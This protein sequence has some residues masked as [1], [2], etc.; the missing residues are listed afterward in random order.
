MKMNAGAGAGFDAARFGIVKYVFGFVLFGAL[1]L[2]CAGR[3]D[4]PQADAPAPDARFVEAVS[5][6]VLGRTEP[7]RVVFTQGRDTS[8]PLPA[9]V[10]TLRPAAGGAVSWQDEYTLVFTPSEP[11]TAGRRYQAHVKLG[12]IEPFAFDFVTAL[13]GLDVTLDPV[14]I[15]VYGNAFVRGRVNAD[16]GT[17]IS[18]IEAAVSSRELG[19]PVWE[20]EFGTH[21][22]TFPGVTLRPASHTVEVEWN[23]RVLGSRDS[24]SAAVS[25][26]GADVFEVT[27]F[28][29]ND[30]VL[31]VSF[32]SPLMANRDLRGFISMDGNTNVRYSVDRNIVRVFG[33]GS[34]GIPPGT[35][36]LF[37][38]IEAHDGRRLAIPVQHRTPVRWELPQIRFAGSG[39]ILPT[40][41]GS[42]MV[43]ET[44][45]VS[46]VLV[47]AFR[48][49]G[50]NMIQFLQVNS[51]DGER[52]LDRVGEPVWTKAFDFPW[53][54]RD[55]NRWIRRGLDL[56]EL[57]R[58]YPDGMFRIRVTFRQRHVRFECTAGHG[59][60]EHLPFPDDTF[61][62]F[63]PA[64]DGEYSGWDFDWGIAMS[65]PG[66]NW[67]D[68]NRFRHDPCHPSFFMVH[69]D[70]NITIGRNVLVSDLGLLARRS[71]DGS[72]L[73]ATTN[74]ISARPERN[75]AF[76]IY[77]FQGRV[78][79]E[80]RTGP[81]GMARVPRLE[82]ARN[83]NRFFVSAESG[84][85][86]AFLRVQ[87]ALALATSHFDVAGGS[88]STDVRGLIYGERGVWRPGD[89][90]YLTFLLSDPLQTLP[91]DHP[92]IFE[93]EDPRGRVVHQRTLTSSV[94][95]FYR[96]TTS[97]SADAPTGH[98]TARVRVGGNVFS[99][100]V[101]VET[102][103]PNRLRMDLDFGAEGMIRS[104]PQNV[105]LEAEWLF[106][107]PAPGLRADVS[108]AFADRETVFP[109]FADFSFR[110]PSRTVS[111]QRGNIWSGTLDDYG[112]AE[113]EMRLN[114]G[115][116]VP[117]MVT[118][119]FMTRVFEP[120][121]VFS[122]EQ[123]SVDYSPYERYVGIRLPRGDAARNMLLTDTDHEAE[124]VVLD[125]DG[126]PVPGEV[127][128]SVAL[129][130][131]N[132]RWWWERG[133]EEPAQFAS[134]LARSPVSRGN[135]T[136]V[137]GRASW[138]FR[139]NQPT[140]G[141]F[142]VIARDTAGGHAAAQVTFIDWPGWAGRPQEGGQDA[143]A[144]LT[145]T[146][147]RPSYNVGETV[148]VSFP[149]NRYATALV[150]V[151][152][153]GQIIRSEWVRGREGTTTIEFQAEP[154]M[155]PNVYVH[156]ALLQP[157]LQTQ[158]DLPIRLY[159]VTPVFIEDSRLILRPR[160]DAPEVWQAES[161][162]SF[163]V[164]EATGRPMAYT[165]AVVDEGLLG[166]T[167]FSLPNP[168]N[169]F[170]ARE[171]SFLKSWD[172]F[173]DVIGAHSGRLETLLAIGGGGAG[174]DADAARET[175]R[176]RPVV[177]FFGPYEL[178]AGGQ[179]THTFDLPPYIGALRVMVLAASATSERRPAGV[180]R[181]YGTAEQTVR[182]TSD[183]MV[184]GSL[185]RVLSP[186][187]EVVIPVHVNSYV[188]GRRTVRV[189]LSVP[190]A[191]ILGPV[192]RDVVFDAPGERL[193]RFRARAPEV[194]GDLTFTVSAESAGLETA[195]HVTEMEVRS[196]ALPVTR[197][198]HSLVA[199]GETWGGTLEYPGRDGT[200]RLSLTLSRLPPINLDARLSFLITYPHGCLEQTTSGLFPQLYL[201]RIV[202]L[203]D[204]RRA[205]IRTNVTVGIERIAAFQVPSGGFSFWP[206]GSEA[207]DWGT[208]YAG[209]FLLEA[210][211]AGFAVPEHV[212]QNWLRFQRERAAQWQARSGGFTEQA[213]RLY[214]LALA[215]QADLGSMNR[216]RDQRDLPLQARWRLAAAYWHS[217][218][219]DAA[220]NMTRDLQL[221]DDDRRELSGTFGSRL[222]D[223]AMVLQT[224]IL[225]SGGGAG[226]TDAA[227]ISALFADIAGTLSGDG[228]LSTQET[229][230]ALMAVAPYIRNNS[231]NDELVL[232]VAAAGSNGNVSF[233]GPSLE[234]PFGI[235]RGT[236]GGFEVTNNS[237]SPVYATF[238]VWGT[239]EE[240]GEPAVSDGLA[241][242]VAYLDTDGRPVEP[243]NLRLGQDMEVRVTVRNT[244]NRAVE[245]IALV[246][247]FPA[248]LEIIN[249][250]LAGIVGSQATYRF[251]DIRDDRVKTYFDL[252]RGQSRTF[253]F[254]VTKTYEGYFFRPAIHVYAMY[255]ESIRALIPGVR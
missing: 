155:V 197:S 137:D 100:T 173:R 54:A 158:N 98:W 226:Q 221:P 119:R 168:R 209:H 192:Y 159:G 254:R 139:V 3:D 35:E 187:D 242:E 26:P 93:F 27:E 253:S 88:P 241:L 203:D 175:Q 67:W 7:I 55:Q 85:G 239:P 17:A 180:Q 117:G 200:N 90:V 116:R 44:R 97:T 96:I 204:D 8:A 151:E 199:P 1:V 186:N 114:P 43:V 191:T 75:V 78:L 115:A 16:A 190:G 70:H 51:M 65:V 214:T 174:D 108:V 196:T 50:N 136:A 181:A 73:I 6:G 208:T 46:G 60:F 224:L 205:Q 99:R 57:S 22:F 220:R 106:G 188:E 178:E 170:Y 219:R 249:T 104:G 154:Y 163:T 130:R 9:G 109:G 217:G 211:R 206:G 62:S 128:L 145:L 89:N 42:Q 31:E 160:I 91:P 238:T 24:G 246:V 95:G 166:L 112:R 194:P 185:P 120:S 146:P 207:H 103:M 58:R 144:T 34:G 63:R 243:E 122:S 244:A 212:V 216:L 61:P 229:A 11:L 48:I 251:Q 171:A 124:I 32:S 140:W 182:V 250:R 148:A 132:W 142:L 79:H 225:I 176:F 228:W 184:F 71:L 29:L 231:G 39:N 74:L 161:R 18:Q 247:P 162:V 164:S 80:G 147:E 69:S 66:F 165:V 20:H 23:G 153:G 135:V 38:D 105:S 248:S 14:V 131:L 189:S 222:R 129:Y 25:I 52:E 19:T 150:I 82:T 133:A 4:G 118:A 202:E 195:R 172:V 87:D 141:R 125:E 193:V 30:G 64:G 36:F 102:V 236:E 111:A 15:D 56:S 28:R 237:A 77:N 198:F 84:L 138:T 113:F 45:N 59:S 101:N 33:D 152:K 234:I 76:R 149:S 232:R 167:R 81:D 143:Q 213:Y 92:V 215:G 240:G 72:W 83:D 40:S 233:S 53:A 134:A 169:V 94:D 37:Q 127:T 12:D 123:V 47:E 5:G 157:H 126:N 223:R 107:A 177:L 210:R 86:R 41:Q 10:F 255:D 179:R 2:S 252:N 235:V 110:D 21:R 121:G 245:E 218:Q 183:L 156:V 201:D 230:F 13:P 227:R 49:H 68:L